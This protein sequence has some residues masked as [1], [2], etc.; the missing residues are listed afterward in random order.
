[1]NKRIRYM[2]VGDNV[3]MSTRSIETSGG[4][5]RVRYNLNNMVVHILSAEDEENTLRTFV[6]ANV[7]KMKKSIKDNLIEMGAVFEKET[8]VHAE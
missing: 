8:R 4:W 7:H 5:V 1:M 6:A 3:F 2:S